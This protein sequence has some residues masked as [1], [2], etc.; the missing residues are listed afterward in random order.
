M[1]DFFLIHSFHASLPRVS[2]Q[3]SSVL[4]VPEAF[5]FSRL[6]GAE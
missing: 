2:T 6:Q 5:R 3:I 1:S 4:A